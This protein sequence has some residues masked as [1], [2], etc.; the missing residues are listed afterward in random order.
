[1]MK[2]IKENLYQIISIPILAGLFVIVLNSEI[3]AQ[4][5]GVLR[6]QYRVVLGVAEADLTGSGQMNKII[7]YKTQD[8]L[9]LEV[10][11][12]EDRAKW[13]PQPQLLASAKLPDKKDGYFT[14]NGQV[15]NLAV[16]D[17]NGD[18]KLEILATSFD[19]N[20]VAHIN[21]YRFDP[22][23]KQLELIKLN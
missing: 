14:L 5:R 12:Y 13:G 23:Q 22:H 20:L 7:K 17:L 1:M 9:F 21:A 3:R 10:Y 2:W 19:D 6:P 16:D 8:G 4:L 11:G 18:H 15:T